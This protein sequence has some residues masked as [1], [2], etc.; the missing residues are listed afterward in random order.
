VEVTDG[1][2]PGDVVVAT[3]THKVMADSILE[4]PRTDRDEPSR[5]TLARPRAPEAQKAGGES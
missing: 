5:D 4:D 2:A 1:I 3:G